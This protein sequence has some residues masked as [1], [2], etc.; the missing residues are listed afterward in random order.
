MGKV[1]LCIAMLDVM[2]EGQMRLFRKIVTR[3]PSQWKFYKGWTTKRV[4][5]VSRKQCRP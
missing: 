5:N 3:D 2:D 4:G 1:S